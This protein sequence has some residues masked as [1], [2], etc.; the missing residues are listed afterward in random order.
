[1]NAK[2]LKILVVLVSLGLVGGLV[3]ALVSLSSFSGGKAPRV[4]LAEDLAVRQTA[5]N[6]LQAWQEASPE[7]MYGYL[8]ELD[9][10]RVAK[11]EYQKHFEA[12][13]VYPLHFKLGTVKLV[14]ADKATVSVRV[15][16]P[17]PAQESDALEKDEQLVLVRENSVWR[18]REAESLN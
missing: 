15:L 6:Y 16:W 10:A 18:V 13:P 4:S 9:K 14:N 5:G 17:E 7:R 11:D 8:S 2:Q 3:G 1:M 12:F